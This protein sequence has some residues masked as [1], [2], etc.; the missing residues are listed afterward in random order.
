VSSSP[1]LPVSRRLRA[2]ALPALSV[3]HV[4][5]RVGYVSR[6][7]IATSLILLL[8]WQIAA[9]LEIVPAMFLPSPLAVAAKFVSVSRAWAG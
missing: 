8:L 3:R 2:P 6:V 9:A 1:S 7:S 4:F 5:G